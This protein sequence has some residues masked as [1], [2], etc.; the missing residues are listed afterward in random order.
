V[1]HP[2]HFLAHAEGYGQV[3]ARE[4][5]CRLIFVGL[6]SPELAAGKSRCGVCKE[7]IKILG[8]TVI[9]YTRESG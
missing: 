3:G 5:L 8:A 2:E 7:R 1:A 9:D 6:P 4:S